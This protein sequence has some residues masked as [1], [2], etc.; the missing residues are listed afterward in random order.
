MPFRRNYTVCVEIAGKVIV[1]T[2]RAESAEEAHSNIIN[3]V[4]VRE[5]KA[6]PLAD[7]ISDIFAMVKGT[8]K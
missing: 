2:T 7:D 3:S 1:T 6:L 4:K 5:V 8:M